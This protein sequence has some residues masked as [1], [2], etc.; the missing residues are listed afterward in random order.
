MKPPA[1]AQGWIHWLE[2]GPGARALA[3]TAAALG[4]VLLALLVGAKQFRGPASETT[5]LQAGVGRELATGR[6]FSSPVAYPQTVTFLAQ[7]GGAPTAHGPWPELTLP[8]LYPLA[9]ALALTGADATTYA[10]P[11]P[12]DGFG[13]DYRLLGLNLLLLLLAAWQ[14]RGLA[15]RLFDPAVGRLAAAGL[16]LS[17]PLWQRAV[18]VD[19]TALAMVVLL[20][21]AQLLERTLTAR[22]ESRRTAGWEWAVGAVAALL[23]LTDY[24]AAILLPLLMAGLG[25]RR[26]AAAGW[27]LGG[28]LLVAGPWMVRNVALTGSPVGLAWHEGALRAADPTADPEVRRATF[29]AEAPGLSLNKVANKALTGLQEGLRE[30]I[31]SG[32][33]LVFAAFF[34]AG[35]LYSFRSDTANALRLAAAVGLFAL[36]GA[37]AVFGSGE[38]ERHPFAY[39][40]PLLI[41][42]GAAFVRILAGSRPRSA[43]QVGGVLATVLI[44]HAIPLL[45]DV[46]EPRGVHF[47]FPPYHPPSF[48]RLGTELA[49]RTDGP[50]IW[51]ADVPAG[52]AWYSGT[53]VW[54]RPAT[55]REFYAWSV[56]HAP[57]ALVLTPRTLDRPYFSELTAPRP[58]S[59]SFGDWDRVYAGLVTQRLPN[60]FPLTQ[61]ER[62]ADNFWVLLDPSQPPRPGM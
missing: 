41:L 13:A 14:V 43:R 37:T 59:P 23:F 2:S 56:D 5:L 39:G 57:V 54:A 32:G 36:L 47:R 26:P 12:P 38:G 30:R 18:A 28:F 9:V 4:A 22:A 60:G 48:A 16:L 58:D 7:R 53:R 51:A 17:A 45:Q 31:W 25:W 52:A 35:G 29:S 42:F 6:G 8:P 15:G 40:A 3:W 50:P 11:I 10:A 62:L 20:A 21:L 44:L 49:R 34:V 46:L 1:S 55:L 19:G 24:P 33:A 61:A 27:V